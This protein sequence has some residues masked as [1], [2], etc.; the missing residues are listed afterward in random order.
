MS[1]WPGRLLRPTMTTATGAGRT[2]EIGGKTLLLMTPHAVAYTGNQSW[3]QL[4]G[5]HSAEG[6]AQSVQ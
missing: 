6:M 2:P 3:T 5:F 4:T 1:C